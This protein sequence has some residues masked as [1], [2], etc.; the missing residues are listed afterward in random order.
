[1]QLKSFRRLLIQGI[2]GILEQQIFYCIDTVTGIQRQQ[3]QRQQR[4][5]PEGIEHFFMQVES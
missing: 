3:H 5:R 2:G 1:M 4:Q